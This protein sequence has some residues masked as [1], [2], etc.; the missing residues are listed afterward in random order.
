MALSSDEVLFGRIVVHN[1]LASDS[2]VKESMAIA[3]REGKDLGTVLRAKGILSEKQ[4][5][6]IAQRVRRK[7][8]EQADAPAAAYSRSGP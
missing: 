4:V 7:N 6:L 5:E 1:K 2:Q 8:H 3:E